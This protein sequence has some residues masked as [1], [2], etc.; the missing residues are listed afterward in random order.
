MTM[1]IKQRKIKIEPGIK[2]NY[3]IS[4]IDFRKQLLC[5]IICSTLNCGVWNAWK[6]LVPRSHQRL[7]MFKCCLV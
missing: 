3:N 4:I 7:N 6:I 1:N 5:D 2:L